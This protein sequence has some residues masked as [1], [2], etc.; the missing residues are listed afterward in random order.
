MEIGTWSLFDM[1][2][3]PVPGGILWELVFGSS[4]NKAASSSGQ[5]SI[6]LSKY[7]PVGLVAKGMGSFC[8][9]GIQHMSWS[10]PWSSWKARFENRNGI[11]P[12]TTSTE[13]H[14]RRFSCCGFHVA[15]VEFELPL[16]P[17]AM[18]CSRIEILLDSLSF[19]TCWCECMAKPASGIPT[20]WH[21]WCTGPAAQVSRMAWVQK[22]SRLLY[23]HSGVFSL[24]HGSWENRDRSW[25]P[26]DPQ[27]IS[28]HFLGDDTRLSVYPLY[29]FPA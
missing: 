5:M 7:K 26:F 29:H 25:W 27:G 4:W 24:A 18:H 11:K 15:W 17:W 13:I 12:G 21:R 6:K 10:E 2:S 9:L 8:S 1:I 3:S 23:A 14:D 22:D 20:F 16:D 19:W 28:R